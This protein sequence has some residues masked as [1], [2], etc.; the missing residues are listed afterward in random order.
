MSTSQMKIVVCLRSRDRCATTR[1]SRT[2]SLMQGTL[3]GA[4][5]ASFEISL[6]SPSTQLVHEYEVQTGLKYTTEALL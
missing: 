3:V 2:A 6:P 5:V 1:G 4:C